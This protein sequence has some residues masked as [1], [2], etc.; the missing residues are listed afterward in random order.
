VTLIVGV[1][2]GVTLIVGVGV[3]TT[4]GNTPK[5]TKTILFEKALEYVVF[6]NQIFLV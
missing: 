4:G 5:S 6:N 1:L 2:L 3:K